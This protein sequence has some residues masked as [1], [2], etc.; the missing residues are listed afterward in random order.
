MIMLGKESCCP[1]CRQTF[2]FE[3]GVT[4][5]EH[6]AR[7]IINAVTEM[8]EKADNDDF[9]RC[10]RC[11]QE[12]MLPKKTRNAFSRHADIYI[13]PICGTDEAVRDY[14]GG[15][16]PISDWWIVREILE[17]RRLD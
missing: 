12:R 7:G 14:T 6:L 11:G 2:V 3:D 16:L 15:V 13:C 5:D 9:D 8:Q 4:A 17:Y 1:V 10:L